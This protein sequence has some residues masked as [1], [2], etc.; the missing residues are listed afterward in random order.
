MAD[1]R[2]AQIGVD[3]IDYVIAYE[4]CHIHHDHH[5]A[6]FYKLLDCAMPGWERRKIKLERQMS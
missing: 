2:K 4:L 1:S 3:A 5:G 6:K